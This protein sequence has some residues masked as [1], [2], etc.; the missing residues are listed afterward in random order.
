MTRFDPASIS[1]HIGDDW[2]TRT[3][4]WLARTNKEFLNHDGHLQ[5]QQTK[6]NLHLAE[7]WNY[8]LLFGDVLK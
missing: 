3:Q 2:E 5:K 1:I 8:D 7:L 6:H 4:M